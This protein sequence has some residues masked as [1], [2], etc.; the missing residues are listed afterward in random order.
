MASQ[1]PRKTIRSLAAV[2]AMLALMMLSLG[3]ALAQSTTG[4]L[5][6]DNAHAAG[7]LTTNVR[8]L[9]DGGDVDEASEQEAVDGVNN[10]STDQETV[11]ENDQGDTSA[12]EDDQGEDDNSVDENDQ[13]QDENANQD[14]GQQDEADDGGSG[15]GDESDDSGDDSGDN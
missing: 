6:R 15:G 2:I 10:D 13:G 9:T 4:G 3:S 14:D 11:D 8:V 7:A 5:G 1:F 12:D